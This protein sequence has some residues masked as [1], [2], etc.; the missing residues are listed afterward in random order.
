MKNIH[1]KSNEAINRFLDK[2]PE[3]NYYKEQLDKIKLD[4][5]Y[6]GNIIVSDNCGEKTKTLDINLE[7]IPEIRKFLDRMELELKNRELEQAKKVQEY[8][9]NNQE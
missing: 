5:T 6:N 1:A 4:A 7:S 3:F 8:L 2:K 9:K